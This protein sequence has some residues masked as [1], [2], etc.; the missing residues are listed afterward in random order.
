MMLNKTAET[1]LARKYYIK[2][3]KEKPI[4]DFNKLCLRVA[5]AVA[6]AEKTK[7]SRDEWA[8]VYYRLMN[9]LWFL[10]GGRVLANA[11]RPKAGNL[12]N[13][14][15]LPIE[16]SRT[17][18]YKALAKGAQ[19]FAHGGGVGYNFS[20]LREK[21]SPVSNGSKA[22]GP[23]SFLKLFDT[24]AGVISQASRRG[25]QMAILNID[26]PDIRKF[27]QLKTNQKLPHFNLSVGLTD[28]FMEAITDGDKKYL[29]LSRYDGAMMQVSPQ[30]LLSLLAENAWKTGD[31]GVIFTDRIDRDNAT[32]Y[33][34]RIEAL[35]P[36]GE[37]PLL[38]NESCCLGSINLAKM[39]TETDD[40]KLVIDAQK[41][42]YTTTVAIRFLDSIHD[43]NVA[44]LP[45]LNEAALRTRKVGL[46]VCGWADVL[47]IL[48][49]PYDSEKALELADKVAAYIKSAAYETSIILVAEKSGYYPAYDKKKSKNVWYPGKP[50]EP[51]RN[52]ML[53]CLAPTGSIS[54]LM[55]VNSG[56]EPFYALRYKKRVTEGTGKA[57]YVLTEVNKYI[58]K[59]PK[60][61]LRTAHQISPE[62]HIKMQAVWQHYV[63]GAVSK[64]I[65]LP[66]SATVEDIKQAIILGWKLGL[67]G[68]TVFRDKCREEQILNG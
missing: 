39:I 59:C 66:N 29:L 5:V 45:E 19:I 49:I 26:H 28:G 62:W 30:E 21:G 9:E 61:V 63:D 23:V 27:I 4:E 64:T 43:V 1:I 51:T 57:K 32:P 58:D 53:L 68:M 50:V 17:S 12:F 46:G 48:G 65:N 13:C 37:S 54:M 67:K 38:P 35:N 3:R 7:K 6:S 60:E 10:P 14:F 16:D 11:G 22:S 34:G 33:L 24:S 18:I 55:G 2:D 36:C 41:I 47:A 25:A 56:I 52:A 44:I 40:G 31:P 15:V 8:G 42:I 20:K